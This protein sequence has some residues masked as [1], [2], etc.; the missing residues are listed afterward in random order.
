MEIIVRPP[1]T[2]SWNTTQARCVIGRG[3]VISDKK[4]GDGATPAGTFPLRRVMYRPDRLEPPQ[5]G[6]P[7]SALTADDGWCDEPGN[8]SYNRLIKLPF[9][10]SHEALWRDD[11][12]YDVIVELGYNDDPIKPGLGSAIFMHV[13]KPGY[14]PTEGCVALALEDLLE[15]LSQSDAATVLIVKLP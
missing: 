15:L 10:A 1:E 13:A 12:V 8:A 4:E 3:G 2:L 11:N 5:T 9:S 6:L 7:I 14:D